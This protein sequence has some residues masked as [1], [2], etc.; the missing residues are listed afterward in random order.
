MTPYPE[1]LHI[2][3]WTYLSLC[4]LCGVIMIGDELRRPQE[5]MIMNFLWP[6]TALYGGPIAF[7]AYFESR[8]KNDQTA[9]VAD[10]AGGPGGVA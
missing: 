10:E 4:F 7:W 3:S 8:P 1:W 6:I 2:L 5:M 9:H